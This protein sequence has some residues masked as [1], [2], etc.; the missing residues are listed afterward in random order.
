MRMVFILALVGMVL[1]T[2]GRGLCPVVAQDGPRYIYVSAKYV[3]EEHGSPEQPYN[4]ITEA[5]A[6]AEEGDTIRVAGGRG[7][8][9]AENIT[10]TEPV[11]LL[12]GF[13]PETWTQD[14]VSRYPVIDGRGLGTVVVI[15]PWASDR[16]D[17]NFGGFTILNGNGLRGGGLLI[18]GA[19]PRVFDNRISGNWASEGGG[20]A[21]QDASP[22]IW[23]NDI[24]G[25]SAHGCGGGG[26]YLV[27]SGAILS[28]NRITNNGAGIAPG[29]G[30]VIEDHSQPMMTRNIIVSNYAQD[31][32]GIYV[33]DSSQAVASNS[34]IYLNMASGSGGG[35]AV[36]TS[37]L[38]ITNATIISNS[39]AHEGGGLMAMGASAS[40]SVTNSIIWGHGGDDI[41]GENITA[42]YSDV[43]EGVWLGEGNLSLDPRLSAVQEPFFHLRASSPLIDAGTNDIP[44]DSDFEADPRFYDGDGDGIPRADIGA[45]E[46]AANLG[47][48]RKRVMPSDSFPTPGGALKY[49][50]TLANTGY[51]DVPM[52]TLTDT[53]P[54]SLRYREGSLWAARGAYAGSG[55]EITWRGPLTVALPVSITFYVEISG[56]AQVGRPIVN[57]ARIAYGARDPELIDEAVPIVEKRIVHL[58]LLLRRYFR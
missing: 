26:V 46:L 49:T 16:R 47:T 28:Q 8:F 9:Y 34:I 1:V 3:G 20:I 58:P 29:G 57:V 2:A 4:S 56:A 54:D 41:A 52:A 12:G 37:S 39:V 27:R 30:I 11:S 23:D 6:V 14:A 32:A 5:L 48:S 35:I 43:Q 55:G 25:N 38:E 50:I 13:N 53:L 51:M 17:I 33:G 42:R 21:V 31:G 10:V 22:I 40:V 44:L 7:I 15:G 24:E 18:D 45:D 19:S 36:D